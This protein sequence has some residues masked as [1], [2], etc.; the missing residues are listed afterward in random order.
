[1]RIAANLF[2][3]PLAGRRSALHSIMMA[4]DAISL[5]P[6]AYTVRFVPRITCIMVAVAA[7]KPPRP[8]SVRLACLLMG[9]LHMRM[10]AIAS[11]CCWENADDCC[12]ASSCGYLLCMLLRVRLLGALG[13]GRTVVG[14][15]WK[16]RIRSRHATYIKSG[17][18]LG[19]NGDRLRVGFGLIR[20][21]S[22]FFAKI[23]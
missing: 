2:T 11:L 1:V 21:L 20:M 5:H 16:D 17:L 8:C 6:P 23:N 15:G 14:N 7:F 10:R 13:M 19:L 12:P 4:G 9:A 18:R 3:Q 22:P